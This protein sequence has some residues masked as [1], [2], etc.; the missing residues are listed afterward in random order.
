MGHGITASRAEAADRKSPREE[1][2]TEPAVLWGRKRQLEAG[3]HVLWNWSTDQGR[4]RPG[5]P[6]GW[7]GWDV[8]LLTARG[9]ADVPQHQLS[10][11]KVGCCPFSW[12]KRAPS[13][14]SSTSG[15]QIQLRPH[16]PLLGLLVQ[17]WTQLKDCHGRL[18]LRE[19]KA[20]PCRASAGCREEK[21]EALQLSWWITI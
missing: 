16:W 10:R 9:K 5:L 15:D 11:G 1:S 12:S 8:S 3:Q 18:Q 20:E 4:S 7:L 14:P 6:G 21:A 19:R 13:C 2:V 17:A